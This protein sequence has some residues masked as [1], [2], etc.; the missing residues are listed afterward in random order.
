[1][2]EKPPRIEDDIEEPTLSLREQYIKHKFGVIVGQAIQLDGGKKYV[3][4]KITNRDIIL[5]PIR[6]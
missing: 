6:E 1:M 3:V 2:L 4:R 5:R